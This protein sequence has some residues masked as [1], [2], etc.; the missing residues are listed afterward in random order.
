MAEFQCFRSWKF[1]KW[2]ISSDSNFLN[3]IYDNACD[4]LIMEDRS[5]VLD[6][7]VF[8]N[9]FGGDKVEKEK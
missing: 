5:I 2:T 8:I 7:V 9:L 4:N 1:K 3:L 6:T